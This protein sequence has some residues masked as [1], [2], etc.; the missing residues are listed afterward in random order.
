M[1]AS[2]DT[3]SEVLRGI[4]LV[5]AI[6]FEVDGHAPWASA[7]P[8][9]KLIASKVLPGVQHL[10]SYHVV[11]EGTCWATIDG[12][13][14]VQLNSGDIIVYPHGDAHVVSS[15]P[16]LTAKPDLNNYDAP[17]DLHLPL[18][19]AIGPRTGD[20]VHIVCGFLGCD[21]RPF[22]PLIATL[23]RFIHIRDRAGATRGWLNQ[24][25]QVAAAESKD[26]R[27]GSQAVLSR[28]SELMFVEAVRRHLETLPSDRTGWLAGLRDPAVGRA[29]AALHH[30]PQVPWTLAKLAEASGVSRSVL[31]ERFATFVGQP[32]MQYLLQWRMQL[33]ARALEAGRK[34]SNV[35]YEVGYESEAAFSRAFK[36]LTGISP[37]SWRSRGQLAGSGAVGSQRHRDHSAPSKRTRLIA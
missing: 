10:I 6:F 17:P 29:L 27:P 24:F 34:V 25:V 18:S 1:A 15:S 32:P 11:T 16:E 14:S 33:G 5:G 4:H 21:I 8:A 22:N 26:K 20:R 9:G 12:L 28:M 23:P 36:K 37:G 30:Q 31:A 7:A 19:V 3:L 13:P 2:I 35:A